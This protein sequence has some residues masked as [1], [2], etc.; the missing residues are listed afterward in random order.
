MAIAV[1]RGSVRGVKHPGA[2]L[3][4]SSFFRKTPGT[5]NA[6]CGTEPVDR[7]PAGSAAKQNLAFTAIPASFAESFTPLLTYYCQEAGLL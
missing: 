7:V 5:G 3:R 4:R 6:K 2:R 1:R